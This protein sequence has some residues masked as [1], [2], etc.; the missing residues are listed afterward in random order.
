MEGIYCKHGTM[1]VWHRD[2]GSSVCG[3]CHPSIN[4]ETAFSRR[5]DSANTLHPPTHSPITTDM[6]EHGLYLKF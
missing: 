6:T 3:I 5:T 4:Q 1:A 2:D